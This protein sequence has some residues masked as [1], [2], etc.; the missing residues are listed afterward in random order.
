MLLQLLSLHIQI[1]D[2]TNAVDSVLNIVAGPYSEKFFLEIFTG[3]N[4]VVATILA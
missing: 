1:S 4:Y 3:C 2:K